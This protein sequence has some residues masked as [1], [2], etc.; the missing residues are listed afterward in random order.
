M[1][2]TCEKID[3]ICFV[4][5]QGSYFNT[6]LVN[7]REA[8]GVAYSRPTIQNSALGI[9]RHHTGSNPSYNYRKISQKASK[10]KKTLLTQDLSRNPQEH[11]PR[12]RLP[13]ST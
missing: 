2:Q 10:D 5:K 6:I 1:F 7:F 3:L 12:P 11:Q 8:K 4:S 9:P 13:F